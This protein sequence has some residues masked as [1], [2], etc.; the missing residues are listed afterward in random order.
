MLNGEGSAKERRR[1]SSDV[2]A[3]SSRSEREDVYRKSIMRR[4]S[5]EREDAYQ[6]S[7]MR[8]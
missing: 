6:K 5:S 7:I 3:A 4:V 8:R 1:F 2:V